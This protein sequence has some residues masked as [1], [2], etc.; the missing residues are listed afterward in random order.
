MDGPGDDEAL[1]EGELDGSDVTEDKNMD[2]VEKV[3]DSVR[4]WQLPLFIETSSIAKSP[5]KEDPAIPSNV[6]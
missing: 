4:P 6:T 3:E 5:L 2:V 1:P